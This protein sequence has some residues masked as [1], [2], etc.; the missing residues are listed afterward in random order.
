MSCRKLSETQ[1]RLVRQANE[2]ICGMC[3]DKTSDGHKYWRGVTER[4][5]DMLRNETCDGKPLDFEDTPK[6]EEPKSDTGLVSGWYVCKKAGIR[7]HITV[8]QVRSFVEY[9]D[10]SQVVRHNTIIADIYTHLP[11]C[12]GWD[13]VPPP[14][15]I[16]RKATPEDWP[17]HYGA[18]CSPLCGV[19][20]SWVGFVPNAARPYIIK[21]D[22]C[23]PVMSYR[24]ISIEVPEGT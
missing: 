12:D 14:K 9:K 16:T 6:P 21:G 8:G 20:Y 19:T 10:G 5:T 4:L 2:A 17:K 18:K 3:W 7:C 23:G 24:E 15:M 13:W 1:L 11:D 22:D